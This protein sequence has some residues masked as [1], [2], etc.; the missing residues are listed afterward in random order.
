MVSHR[1]GGWAASFIIIGAV[2]LI[3]L[4]GGVY[5]LRTMQSS[6]EQTDVTQEE[7]SDIEQPASDDTQDTTPTDT[8]EAADTSETDSSSSSSDT[9]A[10]EQTTS[11][12]RDALPETG[13]AEDA[14]YS[15]VAL[16]ALT[17]SVAAFVISRQQ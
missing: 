14:L 9:A 12:S 17:F 8:D 4:V 11:P 1:Q 3:A 13:P 6:P 5:Y 10:S 2:L 15:V 16:G 7:S